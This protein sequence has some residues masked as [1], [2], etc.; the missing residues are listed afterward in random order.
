M[1]ERSERI[2]STVRLEARLGRADRSSWCAIPW[3][4]HQ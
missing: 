1:S 3:M 2:M 4:V